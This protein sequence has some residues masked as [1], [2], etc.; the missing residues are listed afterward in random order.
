MT[1]EDARAEAREQ[2]EKG[3]FVSAIAERIGSSAGVKAVFGEPVESE[4][5][6]VIPV[7]KVRWGAGGGGG[8]EGADEGFGG[9]GGAA[10]APHGFIELRGGEAR[11]RRV[12]RPMR[13]LLLALGAALLCAAAGALIQ[14]CDR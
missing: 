11:Y 13:T 6:T 1:E 4:G 10:A 12:R 7:A 9:G 3:D 5:V 14:Q 8:G 2:V